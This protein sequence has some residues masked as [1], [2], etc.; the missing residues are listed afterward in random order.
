M[1][2]RELEGIDPPEDTADGGAD[3]SGIRGRRRLLIGVVATAVV[4]S[5]GGIGAT[6]LVK[7]PAELAASAGPPAQDVLTAPV[8]QRVLTDS[9]VLRGTVSAAQSIAITPAA[10]GGE[11]VARAVVTKT[12]V[13]AGETFGAGKVLLEV[14]GRPLFALPGGLPVY[15]DLKPGS[16]GQDVTQLQQALTGLGHGV[17]GDAS[18]TFGTGTQSALSS[19]Y[20]AIGYDPLPATADGDEAVASAQEAVTAAGRA[21]EDARLVKGEDATRQ[22]ARAKE[23]LASAKAKLAQARSASGPMLP[24]AEVVYLRGFPARVDA[25][26]VSVGTEAREKLMTVSA[27]ELVLTGM[28]DA[29]QKGLIRPGQKV[30][31]L[32]EVTG[33]TATATVASVSDTPVQAGAGGGG[34]GSQGGQGGQGGGQ[35]GS[36]GAPVGKYAMVAKPDE[37]LPA[38]LAGQ[39]VRLTVEAASSQGEV[40]VVPVSAVSAG[41]DGRTTVTVLD[42]GNRRTRVEVRTGTSGDGYVEVAVVGGG[43]L[44]KGDSVVI[45]VRNGRPDPGASGTG[46]G[47]GSG[48]GSA[49]GSGAEAG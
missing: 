24:A 28:L 46:S 9:V 6:A 30:R 48:D 19:F 38:A 36:A 4:L 18:G 33:A 14:S 27:G 17:R 12:P 21:L 7:S 44:A 39:D 15:R 32:S 20:A 49:P 1:S 22:L 23:D 11:G 10:G 40:L 29:G 35:G 5:V 26:N 37:T 8:E 42:S 43:E 31:V 34:D 25:V 2:G 16:K 45:G 41:A 3:S 13:A 47:G